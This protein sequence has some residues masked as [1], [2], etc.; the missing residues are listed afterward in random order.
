MLCPEEK[1][2][3]GLCPT[4][5]YRKD[6]SAP[7][8]PTHHNPHHETHGLVCS[9]VDNAVIPSTKQSSDAC[10][11]G[12]MCALQA[13]RAVEFLSRLLHYAYSAKTY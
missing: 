1:Q 3:L 5:P 7:H 6:S 13:P 4:F 11:S 10:G 2:T 9:F 12:C 8:F